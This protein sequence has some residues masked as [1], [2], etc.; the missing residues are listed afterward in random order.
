VLTSNAYAARARGHDPLFVA[1]GEPCIRNIAGP[2]GIDAACRGPT[3]SRKIRVRARGLTR[4]ARRLQ[5][6]G[7]T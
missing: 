7:R 1:A 4:L 5:G 2:C 3:E 6:Y